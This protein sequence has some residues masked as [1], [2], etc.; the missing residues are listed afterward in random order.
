MAATQEELQRLNADLDEALIAYFDLFTEYQTLFAELGNRLKNVRK[1][2]SLQYHRSEDW[3]RLS[4]VQTISP[5]PFL[6]PP[7]THRAGGS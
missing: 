5:S 3:A 7:P 4:S 1:S 6:P 2:N